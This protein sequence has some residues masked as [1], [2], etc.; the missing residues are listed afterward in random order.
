M[1]KLMY[2]RLTLLLKKYNILT[3]AQNGYTEKKSTNTAIQSFVE[4]IQG[5]LDSGLHETG[6]FFDLT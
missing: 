6:I 5:A 2:D 3:E 1:E 4:R